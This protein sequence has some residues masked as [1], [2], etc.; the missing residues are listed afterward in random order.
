MTKKHDKQASA[1][2][3]PKRRLEALGKSE[4]YIHKNRRNI[5]IGVIVAIVVI[6]G[7]L[8]YKYLYAGTIFVRIRLMRRCLEQSITLM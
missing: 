1:T 2:D 3:K 8:A 4:A 7:V 5:L 6:G